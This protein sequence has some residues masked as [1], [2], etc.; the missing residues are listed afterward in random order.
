MRSEELKAELEAKEIIEWAIFAK[1]MRYVSPEEDALYMRLLKDASKVVLTHKIAETITIV[2]ADNNGQAYFNLDYLE[3][4]K[5]THPDIVF[6]LSTVTDKP[7]ADNWDRIIFG[8]T[9]D[10]DLIVLAPLS[11]K[12]LLAK[13]EIKRWSA[14]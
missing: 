10:G 4:I 13:G 12:H 11:R 3:A 8:K 7:G 6:L 14:E 9:E 2:T 1:T 5:T